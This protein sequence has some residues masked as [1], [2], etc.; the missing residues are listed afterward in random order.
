MEVNG[1]AYNKL[2]MVRRYGL[3][4]GT[5]CHNFKPISINDVMF[6]RNAILNYY[7][8]NVFE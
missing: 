7:D 1:I 6:Y 4:V 5:D 8:E 2:Q 3:N